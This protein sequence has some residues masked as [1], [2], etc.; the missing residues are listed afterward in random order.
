MYT[1]IIVGQGAFHGVL[2]ACEMFCALRNTGF[3]LSNV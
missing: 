2:T 3:N 1:C